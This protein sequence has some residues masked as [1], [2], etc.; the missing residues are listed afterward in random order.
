[1]QTLYHLVANCPSYHDSM[2]NQSLQH[3]SPFAT[4]NRKSH[5]PVCPQD[6]RPWTIICWQNG[7]TLPYRRPTGAAQGTHSGESPSSFQPSGAMGLAA[8]AGRHKPPQQGRV[9]GTVL[10][11]QSICSANL[12]CFRQQQQQQLQWYTVS[13]HPHK[14]TVGLRPI[15]PCVRASELCT[16][17]GVRTS[18]PQQ[19]QQQQQ[20]QQ[21]LVRRIVISPPQD[22][23]ARK[24]RTHPCSRTSTSREVLQSG[25][26]STHMSQG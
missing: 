21:R 11:A 1:M 2:A 26:I 19:Q 5:W 14:G 9:R 7:P 16:T 3:S 22:L 25:R 15:P 12:A 20:R 24:P 18:Q 4:T 8:R 10:R 17:D 13:M 6:R 23:Q